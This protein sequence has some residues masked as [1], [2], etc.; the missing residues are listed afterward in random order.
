MKPPYEITSI[1]L[2]LISSIS[3]K[4]GEINAKYLPR[5]SPVLRK[6]NKIKTIHSSLKIEGN[7]LSEEQVTA[8]VQNKRVI[9]SKKDILEVNNAIQVYD[10]IGSY[11]AFSVKSFL[12]AHKTLMQGLAEKAGVFRT[13]EVGIFEG[14]NIAHLAPPAKYVESQVKS[15]FEYLIQ[16]DELILI[17]SCVFHYE[18]EFIHPFIDGNGRMGRLWQTV[19]LM[20]EHPVFE[21]IPFETLISNSHADYYNALAE[22]DKAGKSTKF[23]EYILDIIDRSLKELLEL[24]SK[25]LT[26]LDR[27]EYFLSS[28]KKEFSRKDFM[29]VFKDISSATAS[30]DLKKGIE[31]NL[32]TKSGNKNNTIYK[33]V[34]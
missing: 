7:S 27:L 21:F 25:K 3:E 26:S 13:E 12:A 22:S 30:R 10:K 4:I 2:K 1:T 8:L 11:K 23:I 24:S 33:P 32:L 28:N 9:G 16:S 6:K 19:L 29:N 17:K 20:N 14:S 31:L 15:L 34:V 5:P 18:I